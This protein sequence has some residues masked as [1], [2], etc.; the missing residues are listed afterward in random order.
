MKNFSVHRHSHTLTWVTRRTTSLISSWSSPRLEL[1]PEGNCFRKCRGLKLT[2]TCWIYS[3]NIIEKKIRRTIQ[4]T[5]LQVKKKKKT[6]KK[7]CQQSTCLCHF[8]HGV[9]S[10]RSVWSYVA[11]CGRTGTIARLN[12]EWDEQRRNNK[13]HWDW[14]AGSVMWNMKGTN[15]VSGWLRVSQSASSI[16][17]LLCQLPISLSEPWPFMGFGSYSLLHIPPSLSFLMTTCQP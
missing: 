7:T 10:S 2:M 3:T 16:C 17:F 5:V 13:R 14:N 11:W 1:L 8:R 12:S 9:N 15:H 6:R 4:S